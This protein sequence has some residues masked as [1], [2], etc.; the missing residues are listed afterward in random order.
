MWNIEVDEEC[1]TIYLDDGYG[2]GFSLDFGELL[3]ILKEVKKIQPA[4]L[5][6]ILKSLGADDNDLS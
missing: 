2:E 1:P 4:R 6:K 3:A 5:T